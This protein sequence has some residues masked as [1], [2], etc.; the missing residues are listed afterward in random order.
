MPGLVAFEDV[1]VVAPP[2]AGPLATY[3]ACLSEPFEGDWLL[4]LQ[5]DAIPADGFHAAVCGHLRRFD[6]LVALFLAGA[7]PSA[8]RAATRAHSLGHDHVTLTGM[9]FVPT[10]ALAWPRRVVELFHEWWANEDPQLVARRLKL[11]NDD[12]VIG[13]FAR[14]SSEAVTVLVPSIVQHPDDAPSTC[15]RRASNGRNRYRVAALFDPVATP[16]D[17]RYI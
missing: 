12:A 7:P 4:V 9:P 1:R 2:P 10:V 17:A 15:G 16:P 3:L 8:A 5:D 14:E 11:G 6:T 13:Q